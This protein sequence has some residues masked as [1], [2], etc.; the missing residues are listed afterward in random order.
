MMPYGHILYKT[1]K[2]ELQTQH[3]L[4]KMKIT[5]NQ[6][7]DTIMYMYIFTLK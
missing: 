7:I 3:L 4:L 2:S 1:G 5:L 6:K